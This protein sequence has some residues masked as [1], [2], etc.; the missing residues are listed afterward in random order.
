MK[1]SV[2]IVHLISVVFQ[3]ILNTKI[4]LPAIR[5]MRLEQMRKNI[6]RLKGE[7]KADTIIGRDYPF[8]RFGMADWSVNAMEQPQG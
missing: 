5:E 3:V 4:E 6:S 8:F 2:Y 1:C 7:I